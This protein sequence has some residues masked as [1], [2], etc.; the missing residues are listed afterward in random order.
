MA[1]PNNLRTLIADAT[2]ALVSADYTE[3]Q[4]SARLTDWQAHNPDADVSLQA[5]YQFAQTRDFS[6]SLLIAVL[7]KLQTAG[8]LRE[9]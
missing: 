4:I 1:T 3:T 6:E 2:D 5:A 8:Y 7:E 9:P